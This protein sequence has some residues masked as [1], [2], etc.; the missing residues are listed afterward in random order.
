MGFWKQLEAAGEVMG[1]KTSAYLESTQ[2]IK[3]NEKEV[4]IL[5]N[6]M[7]CHICLERQQQFILIRSRKFWLFKTSAKGKFSF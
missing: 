7:M 3:A 1:T 5:I 2:T 4:L 6:V